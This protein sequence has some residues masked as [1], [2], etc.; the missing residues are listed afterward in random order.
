[1]IFSSHLNA[2]LYLLEHSHFVLK[3]IVFLF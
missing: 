2:A 1:M 3:F